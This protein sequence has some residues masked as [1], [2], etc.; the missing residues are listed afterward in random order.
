MWESYVTVSLCF[1]V[2]FLCVVFLLAENFSSLQSYFLQTEDLWRYWVPFSDG[3]E[4]RCIYPGP[5]VS[6]DFLDS[7][8]VV[9]VTY[10]LSGAAP[11]SRGR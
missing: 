10:L 7:R 8:G 6:C 1:A 2:V 5:A 9:W 4:M 3:E 11:C